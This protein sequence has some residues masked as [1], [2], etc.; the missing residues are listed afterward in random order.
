[1]PPLSVPSAPTFPVDGFT[2][3]ATRFLLKTP[4]QAR[5]RTSVNNRPK[6]AQIIRWRRFPG[7]LSKSQ[8]RSFEGGS[9]MT[10]M[11]VYYGC[12]DLFLAPEVSRSM[13]I[14]TLQR[15]FMHI[16]G[17]IFFGAK[18]VREGPVLYYWYMY[19][20]HYKNDFNNGNIIGCLLNAQN[21]SST[22]LPFLQ[23][24]PPR[25]RVYSVM[26]LESSSILQG[27]LECYRTITIERIR[28][29]V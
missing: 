1:M 18:I 9:L 15:K 25:S 3:G 4:A 27:T 2:T 17:W 28:A 22:W 29:N 21:I 8:N 7:V 5:M 10:A 12:L 16:L 26:N 6:L 13:T 11:V 23:D 14:H 19:T 24:M 20:D